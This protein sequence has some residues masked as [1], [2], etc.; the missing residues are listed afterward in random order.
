MPRRK[1]SLSR[2]HQDN[3]PPS[4]SEDGES[5]GADSSAS[6]A[7][8]G[9]VTMVFSKDNSNRSKKMVTKMDETMAFMQGALVG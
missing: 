2:Y 9:Q 3:H 7:E 1:K 4:D 5:G 6:E 8:E